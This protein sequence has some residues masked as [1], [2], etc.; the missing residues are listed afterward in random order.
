[1]S[2]RN[3]GYAAMRAV[4]NDHNLWCTFSYCYV[5]RGKD[6]NQNQSNSAIGGVAF[7]LFARWQQQFAIACFVCGVRPPNLP[8]PWGLRYPHLTRCVIKSHA[9]RGLHAKWR[10]IP[11]QR[12]S[13]VYE[14]DRQTTDDRPRYG[15]MCSS[16]R[17]RLHCIEQFRLKISQNLMK[18][19]K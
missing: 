14:C 18:L 5:C 4:A 19:W 10:L 8:S 9:C 15:Q 7:F 13:T 6:F 2:Q 11:S 3:A 16:R 1:M 12:L 17:N